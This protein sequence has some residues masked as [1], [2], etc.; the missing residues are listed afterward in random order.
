MLQFALQFTAF[1]V[2]ETFLTK[3]TEKTTKESIREI[4]MITSTSDHLF[5]LSLRS[6]SINRDTSFSNL[7]DNRSPSSVNQ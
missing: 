7:A 5:F 6:D 2:L 4:L 1:V 3:Q